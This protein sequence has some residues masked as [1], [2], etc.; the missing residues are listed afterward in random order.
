MSTVRDA[1]FDVL[2]AHGLT[3]IYSNPGSTEVAFLTDLPDDIEFI[4]ALHEGSVVG[5]ATGDATAS[6]TPTLALVHTTAGLGNAVGA[7]ATARAN[8]APVVVLVGQ[9]DRRHIASEPFLTGRLRDLAGDYPVAVLEPARAAELPAMIAQAAHQA[10]MHRGPA[11][12]IAPMDDWDEPAD[13]TID[14]PAP[15]LLVQSRGADPAV[16]RMLADLLDGA[17]NP[18]IV[19]GS[20]IDDPDNW[21]ALAELVDVL[22]CPVWQE[23]QAGRAAFD[24]TS[25]RFAGHLPAAREQLRTALEPYDLV[26]VVGSLAFRQ[27]LYSP[28]RFVQPSTRV[29]VLTADEHD[30]AMSAAELAIVGDPA[31][32][33]AAVARTVTPRPRREWQ[34]R[35][36]TPVPPVSDDESPINPLHVFTA[37]AERVPAFSTVIEECPS[38]RRQLIDLIPTRQPLGFLTPAMGGLG[39]ALP[40]AIGVKIADPDRPV[41][42]I[43]GDGSS[44]YNIQA[45]WSAARYGVGALFVVMSNS[46]YAVMDRLADLA[47]G[48]APWPGFGEV[49]V[50]TLATGLGCPTKR[51][52]RYDDL[53]ATLDEVIPTLADRREPLVL[54]IAVTRI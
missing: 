47:G 27:Y 39:Y 21:A 18:A 29:V 28:G 48:K 5:M 10:A 54:D 51:I 14:L 3:R 33:M 46:G 34:P 9:Q 50:S 13:D 23:A 7:I 8:R 36:V 6:G 32:T 30:A 16:V 42:A 2:R 43:V 38:T 12:V 44:M 45:L 26:L 20:S 4:L 52:E 11:I 25:P 15:A 41:I 31:P 24:H 49:S 35:K 1:V 40:A 53:V 19:T 17:A 37:I 22:D